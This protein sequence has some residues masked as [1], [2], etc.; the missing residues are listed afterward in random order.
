MLLSSITYF[1][2]VESILAVKSNDALA[3]AVAVVS[4][5]ISDDAELESVPALNVNP[6][7]MLISST[8]PLDAVLRPRIRAVAIVRPEEVIVPAG[9]NEHVEL[10]SV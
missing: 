6:V 4:F 1:L 2:Y 10:G 9:T 5:T 8:A 3:F 7:P